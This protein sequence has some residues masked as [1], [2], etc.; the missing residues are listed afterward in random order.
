[1][2]AGRCVRRS[3]RTRRPR[4]GSC[5]R[6]GRVTHARGSFRDPVRRAILGNETAPPN[7]RSLLARTDGLLLGFMRYF[8]EPLEPTEKAAIAKGLL[9][10]IQTLPGPEREYLKAK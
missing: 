10:E 1:M 3:S 9:G 8:N 6:S 7:V 4:S 5:R 2:R